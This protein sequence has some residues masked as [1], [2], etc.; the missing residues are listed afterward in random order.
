MMVG[1]TRGQLRAQALR[2]LVSGG[3][4][5]LATFALY[6]AL[7]P[8]LGYAGSYSL[9]FAAGIVLSYVLNTRFVFR[10]R[11]SLGTAMAFPLVYVAQYFAGLAVLWLWVE[12]LGL[13][14]RY[15]IL[16]TVAVTVPLTF[17][18]SRLLFHRS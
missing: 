10:T 3:I 15:G 7:L 4:N 13:P 18:L 1:G 14:A 8:W 5:T 6:W 16:A 11:A 12:R 9:A 2:F 17:V